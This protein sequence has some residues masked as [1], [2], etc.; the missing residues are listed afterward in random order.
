MLQNG[1]SLLVA[2]IWPALALQTHCEQ[3]ALKSVSVASK[4]LDEVKLAVCQSTSTCQASEPANLS[5]P[6]YLQ[7]A[8]GA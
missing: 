7:R 1:V 8:S 2:L 3:Q 5:R 4:S 6:D